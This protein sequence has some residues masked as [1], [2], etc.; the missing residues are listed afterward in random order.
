[1]A[2]DKASKAREA[3]VPLRAQDGLSATATLEAS[4]SGLF[5]D[6]SAVAADLA[7]HAARTDNPHAVTAAQVGAPTLVAFNTHHT[8]HENAGADEIDVTGLSGLLADAQTPLAHTHAEADITGLVADLSDLLTDIGIVSTN[9]GLHMADT[10]NPH[11]VTAAQVGAPSTAR[12]LIA[13]AGL[14]GGGTLAADR[15]FNVGAGTGITVNA[16]DVAVNYGTTAITACV[17]NDSR[18][19]D[20]RTPTA[21][22]PTHSSAST[23]PVT[24]TNLAGFPGGTTTYLRA[25]GTFG[26]PA[27]GSATPGGADTQIQLNDGGAFFGEAAFTWTKGTDTLS[28]AGAAVFNDNGADKD[29]RIEGDTKAN[30]FF[31][32]ASTDHVGI[33]TNAPGARL[34]VRGDVIFN[35]DAGDFDFRVEGVSDAN[36]LITDAS[37]NRVGIGVAAPLAKLHVVAPS[38]MAAL[39]TER[40]DTSTRTHWEAYAGASLSWQ[41]IEQL[42][43]FALEVG[44]AELFRAG[45]NGNVGITCVAPLAR[46]QVNSANVIAG[47]SVASSAINTTSNAA[48]ITTT[49][50]AIDV[51]GMLSLGGMRDDAAIS[52]GVFGGVRG[53]KENSTTANTA[54]YLAFY[55]MEPTV[56]FAERMRISSVGNVGIGVSAWGSSARTVLGIATGTEPGSS[57]ADMVQ[58]YSVDISA[59]NASLGLRTETA[60]QAAATLSDR[61]LNIRVNGA[62]YKLLL[63]T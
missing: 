20:A 15:T 38:G 4:V 35:E 33:N 34:D 57:P 25:D 23:D 49:A 2:R 32:D 27:G 7:T 47:T 54:G 55:T 19:S 37:T 13:G 18:L 3:T 30:L 51:G 5:V 11:A 14:T 36:L 56:A 52:P 22:A 21:H 16:N 50:Q 46:W 61:Y 6:I 24:V 45:T 10:S 39:R 44:G 28:V 29:F 59:G 48:V 58:L 9:L 1:M 53:G 41:V 43:A 62:T 63:A 26:T 12:D 40:P 31:V 8:R 42:G 60:V 17:G